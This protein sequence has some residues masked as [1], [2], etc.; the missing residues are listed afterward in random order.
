MRGMSLPYRATAQKPACLAAAFVT[1]LV[2]M[3]DGF[4][5]GGE[6]R[7]VRTAQTVHHCSYDPSPQARPAS[8]RC[9]SCLFSSS[10][11]TLICAALSFADCVYA[12]GKHYVFAPF[13][14]T[15]DPNANLKRE[16]TSCVN[17]FFRWLS[18]LLR[19]LLAA[20]TTTLSAL[21]QVVL[22]VHS[23]QIQPVAM[24][25]Q[26]RLR[27]RLLVRCAT[28]QACVTKTATPNFALTAP[29]GVAGFRETKVPKLPLGGLFSCA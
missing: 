13:V 19:H 2:R 28:T 3:A 6:H 14:G 24:P 23:S 27:A 25:Q 15:V 16:E 7:A 12:H 26:A 22:P 20:W 4:Q 9:G 21:L 8:T 17:Q 10:F 1:G 5:T 29:F 18:F 11:D